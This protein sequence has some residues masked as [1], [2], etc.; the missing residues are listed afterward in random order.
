MKIE[1]IEK[2]CNITTRKLLKQS[3]DITGKTGYSNFNKAAQHAYICKKPSLPYILQTHHISIGG[4]ELTTSVLYS[5]EDAVTKIIKFNCTDKSLIVTL[6][7][8]RS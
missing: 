1:H 3:I 5:V 8:A 6:R 7:F 4:L 2:L